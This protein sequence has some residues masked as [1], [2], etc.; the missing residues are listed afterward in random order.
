MRPIDADAFQKFIEKQDESADY[1]RCSF[2]EWLEQQPTIEAKPIV[3]A[4]WVDVNPNL[5][6][7]MKCSLCG[8][9]IKYSEFFNGN[10][11]Y[12]HK[13]G[14]Q[15]DEDQIADTGKKEGE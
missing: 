15:M 2:E 6:I 8:A 5:H 3:H 10:H 7:G 12:C 14:A 9:R 11:H 1:E 4:H 13:C